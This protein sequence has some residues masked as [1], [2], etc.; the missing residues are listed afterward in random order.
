MENDYTYL[1][2][3][4]TI[5]SRLTT[6]MLR[7]PLVLVLILLAAG[8]AFSQTAFQKLVDG[9]DT[10]STQMADSLPLNSAQ[11]LNWSSAYIGQLLGVPPHFGVGI[12]AGATMIKAENLSALTNAFGVSIPIDGMFPN[13]GYTVEGRIGG[14]ILPFDVGLKVGYLPPVG[15][16]KFQLEYLLVGGDFRYALLKGGLALPELSLGIG[17]NY[18]SG[19]ILAKVGNDIEFSRGTG[20]DTLTLAAP[21]LDFSWE[22]LNF[23]L[24]A[25]ISKSFLIVTPSI[26]AGINYARTK[27]GY[28]A[29]STQSIGNDAT[30]GEFANEF[31][32]EFDGNKGFSSIKEING[33]SLRLFG[34][35]SFNLAVIR[36][37]VTAQAG[38]GNDF[39]FGSLS[40]GAGLAVRFQL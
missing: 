5:K 13:P 27:A 10:F 29:S 12:S 4:N 7:R 35:I 34:G 28:T 1:M 33:Y 9:V 36:I 11:G 14:F 3:T 31:G 19:G 22:T 24:K 26:G 15:P 37:D 8:P 32:V 30:L 6:L 21:S 16:E 25:Q 38:T 23:E 2:K 40:Y 20:T 18:L 17:I 39:N